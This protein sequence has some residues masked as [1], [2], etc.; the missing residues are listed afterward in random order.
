MPRHT[1][2]NVRR[3]RL[4]LKHLRIIQIAIGKF[5]FRI[6]AGNFGSFV[7][8]ANEACHIVFW[9]GM[10][11]F[12]EGIAANITGCSGAVDLGLCLGFAAEIAG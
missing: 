3:C 7:A 6:L 11:D 5:H 10:D 12:V 2:D 8:V 9:V 1:Q 4:F